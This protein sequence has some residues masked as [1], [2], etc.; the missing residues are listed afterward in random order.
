MRVAHRRPLKDE[1]YNLSKKEQ[2]M[3][4]DEILDKISRSGY[5]SLSKEEKSRLFE[6]TKDK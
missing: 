2:Q 3:Q 6:L 5:D 1:E 4:I